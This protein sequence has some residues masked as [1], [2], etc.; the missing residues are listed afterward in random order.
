MTVLAPP[1]Q[2]LGAVQLVGFIPRITKIGTE[3]FT[4]K[5]VTGYMAM[6]PQGVFDIAHLDASENCDMIHCGDL[7]TSKMESEG[8]VIPRPRRQMERLL[9]RTARHCCSLHRIA[10]LSGSVA[11]A[12]QCVRSV[13]DR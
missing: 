8:R 13:C 12:D 3:Q 4:A 5:D 6:N 2:L 1:P 11:Q 7:S 10:S 9:A